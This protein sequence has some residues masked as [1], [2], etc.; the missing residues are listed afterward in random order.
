[1]NDRIVPF[2]KRSALQEVQQTRYLT[3]IP[4]VVECA[5]RKSVTLAE[6]PGFPIV[7][8]I[9]CSLFQGKES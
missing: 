6:K 3:E 5:V 2:F 7:Y 4:H 8:I 9:Q 1:M